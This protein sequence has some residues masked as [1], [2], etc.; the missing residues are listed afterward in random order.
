MCVH[1]ACCCVQ[2]ILTELFILFCAYFCDP[3][4]YRSV[5][6]WRL[7]VFSVHWAYLL[8][9]CKCRSRDLSLKVKHLRFKNVIFMCSGHGGTPGLYITLRERFNKH[10]CVGR[11]KF[12]YIVA[13]F[14]PAMSSA[15]YTESCSQILLHPLYFR[16]TILLDESEN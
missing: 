1:T 15:S 3:K 12:I 5:H 6:I 7:S 16:F 9:G 8:C 10:N 4:S 14:L 2:L 13:R 11:K